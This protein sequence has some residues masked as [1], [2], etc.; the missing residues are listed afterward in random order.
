[1]LALLLAACIVCGAT[2]LAHAN[3]SY[4]TVQNKL[5]SAELSASENTCLLTKSDSGILIIAPLKATRIP[6]S[7]MFGAAYSTVNML[8]KLSLAIA[9]YRSTDRAFDRASVAFGK[10]IIGAASTYNPYRPDDKS[11]GGTETAS[12]EPYNAKTWTAAIQTDLRDKFGGVHYGKNYQPAYALVRSADKQVIVKINDV[13]PL[14]PGRIIDFNKRTMRYFDP[15]LKLGLIRNV[16][17]IPL[18]GK[19]WTP[20]PVE[21]EHLISFVSKLGKWLSPNDTQLVA[22]N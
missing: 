11:A 9:A 6:E 19:E 21:G 16:N 12:G 4:S 1:M 15:T 13:G 18:P 10:A 5:K 22:A 2:Q 7:K 20:G 8:T 14:K 3:S 17:I